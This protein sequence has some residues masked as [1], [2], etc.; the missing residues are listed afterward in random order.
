MAAGIMFFFLDMEH[1]PDSSLPQLYGFAHLAFFMFIE[2]KGTGK[3]WLLERFKVQRF[4]V[5]SSRP[6]PG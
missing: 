6:N 2:K 3:L 1:G 5:K 4:R